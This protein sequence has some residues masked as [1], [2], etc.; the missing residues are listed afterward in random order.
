M[1]R[2]TISDQEVRSYRENG[3]V[4]VPGTQ[5]KEAIHFMKFIGFILCLAL[6]RCA[7]SRLNRKK[8]AADWT[9]SAFCW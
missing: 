1:A 2:G 8:S 9:G 6:E 5:L 3:F 7:T 4:V